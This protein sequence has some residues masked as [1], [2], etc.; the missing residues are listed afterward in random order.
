MFQFENVRDGDEVY[1]RCILVTGQFA[2]E[3]TQHESSDSV[4]VET[5]NGAGETIFPD[6]RWPMCQKWFKALLMLSPG[7]NSIVFKLES[8]QS[9]EVPSSSP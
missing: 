4:L 6:Q 8:G 2:A 1:Q 3:S 5:K 9:A 7:P